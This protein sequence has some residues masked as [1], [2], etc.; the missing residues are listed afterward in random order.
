MIET[1]ARRLGEAQLPAM[2]E[3]PPWERKPPRK[4]APRKLTAEQ[5]AEAR[6]RAQKAGRRYPNLVDNMAVLRKKT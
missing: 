4:K 3:A 5:I 1:V 2:A 6:Q